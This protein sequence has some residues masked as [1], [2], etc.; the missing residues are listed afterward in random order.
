M[1]DLTTDCK[2]LISKIK[3]KFG[4]EI[5]GGGVY[6][7]T[8]GQK[9]RAGSKEMTLLEGFLMG[10]GVTMTEIQ[11]AIQNA[12]KGDAVMVKQDLVPILDGRLVSPELNELDFDLFRGLKFPYAEDPQTLTLSREKGVLVYIEGNTATR[13]SNTQTRVAI[14]SNLLQEID[15]KFKYY[16]DKAN[17]ALLRIAAHCTELNDPAATH[18]QFAT[19]LLENVPTC[20]LPGNIEKG[21]PRLSVRTKKAGLSQRPEEVVGWVAPIDALERNRALETHPDLFIKN[22]KSLSNDPDELAVTHISLN[23]LPEGDTPAWNEM[24]EK[25]TADEWKVLKAYI[26]ATFDMTNTSRQALVLYD[27]GHTGKSTLFNVIAWALGG[28]RNCAYPNPLQS[29]K[30][31]KFFMS[32]VYG[33]HVVFIPDCKNDCLTRTGWIHNYTGNDFVSIQFKGKDAFS[34]RVYGKVFIATNELPSVDVEAAHMKTRLIILRPALTEE[35]LNRLAER[36]ED[37][38]IVRDSEGKVVLKGD[39]KFEENLQKEFWAFLNKCKSCYDELCKGGA[40]IAL[41]CSVMANIGC[42]EDYDTTYALE[43]CSELFVFG[44]EQKIK[45]SD[46]RETM[47]EYIDEHKL[48]N[49]FTVKKIIRILTTNRGVVPKKSLRFNDGTVTSGYEGIGLKDVG[50]EKSGTLSGD[51]LV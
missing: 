38:N 32:E 14:P 9:L 23:G 41:P 7:V 2:E 36:D 16:K 29:P 50:G 12:D 15:R 44:E 3:E 40:R 10:Q 35:A 26:W 27:N 20:I 39:N 5:R 33:K 34:A 1:T 11:Q 17:A 51:L 8:G 28:R 49:T 30:T 21:K 37:G 25:F 24:G 22:L 48:R 13:I 31:D 45:G 42:A 47:T 43:I 6:S 46:F 19:W 18:Q 4:C